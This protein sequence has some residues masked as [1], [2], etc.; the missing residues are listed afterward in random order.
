MG[1]KALHLCGDVIK[2][3]SVPVVLIGFPSDIA[4]DLTFVL[5]RQGCRVTRHNEADNVQGEPAA[6]LV[7]CEGSGWLETIC[8]LRGAYPR[9]FLVAATRLPDYEKWLDGLEAGA[10]DYCCT[11]VDVHELGRLLRRDVQSQRTETAYAKAA[12]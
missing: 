12:S 8:H 5:T 9:V 3:A 10:N 7:F 11:A 1:R 2:G 6:I 4:E